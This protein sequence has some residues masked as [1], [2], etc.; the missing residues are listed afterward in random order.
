MDASIDFRSLH[1]QSETQAAEYGK[2]MPRL[3]D[4]AKELVPEWGGS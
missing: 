3:Y 2:L 1:F 4:L